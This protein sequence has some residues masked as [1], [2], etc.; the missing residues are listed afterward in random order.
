M[1]AKNVR[2]IFCLSL[3]V[4]CL[5]TF[6][7]SSSSD[8]NVDGMVDIADFAVMA[9]QWL[10]TSQPGIDIEWVDIPGGSFL[11]GDSYGEGDANE[12]PVHTVTLDSFKM[13]KYEVTNAQYAAFLNDQLAQEKIKVVD[14][15]VYAIDDQT[16][17]RPWFLTTAAQTFSRIKYVENEYGASFVLQQTD[18]HNRAQHPVNWVTWYGAT[19]FCQAHDCRL[20][21][22]AEWEYAARGGLVQNRFSWGNTISQKYANYRTDPLYSYEDAN[23]HPRYYGVGRAPY[24]SPVGSFPPNDYGLYDM[25]GNNWEWVSDWYDKNYYS[26]SPQTNPTGPV[27][28]TQRIIRGGAWTNNAWSCRLTRRS[29]IDYDKDNGAGFRPVKDNKI[30]DEKT[31][32]SDFNDGTYQGW[33][34][35][36]FSGGNLK[37]LT[38][39][40]SEIQTYLAAEEIVPVGSPLEIANTDM[41]SGDLSQYNTIEWDE[42]IFNQGTNNTYNPVIIVEGNNGTSYWFIRPANIK[43]TWTKAVIPLD[44]ASG[45]AHYDGP[46]T[47]SFSDVIKDVKQVRLMM[48][49]SASVGNECG[50][51]NIYLVKHFN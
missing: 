1:C 29:L 27:N 4:L 50:I 39:P 31:L 17:S 40:I 11:M 34:K 49:I 13:S 43:E 44:D 21:T 20:P 47:N 37:F 19:A 36:N 18:G 33:F 3:L 41:L 25:I 14:G 15:F 10:D 7:Q 8:I 9:S 28:G 42:Y 2:V 38:S 46:S 6:A 48:N 30:E 12:R 5:N 26:Y 23:Y 16:N 22:E 45:W 24:M 51:D 35:Y 32:I